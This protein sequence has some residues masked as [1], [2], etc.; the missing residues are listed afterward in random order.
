MEERSCLVL[1]EEVNRVRLRAN[2]EANGL[3]GEPPFSEEKGKYDDDRYRKATAPLYK[4][5]DP[6]KYSST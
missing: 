6:T 3:A 2:I 5:L 4:P 1:S